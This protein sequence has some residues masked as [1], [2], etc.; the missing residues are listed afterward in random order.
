MVVILSIS[1]SPHKYNGLP[2]KSPRFSG[3]LGPGEG[4]KHLLPSPFRTLGCG[5]LSVFGI[6]R[7]NLLAGSSERGQEVT[8]D[9]RSGGYF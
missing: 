9:R 4:E 1:P 2:L 5:G 8:S 3:G 6:E 7:K